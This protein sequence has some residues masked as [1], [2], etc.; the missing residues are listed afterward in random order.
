[1]IIQKNNNNGIGGL[2]D[3]LPASATRPSIPHFPVLPECN[4]IGIGERRRTGIRNS[5]KGCRHASLFAC[6][7]YNARIWGGIALFWGLMIFLVSFRMPLF[8]QE[9]TKPA[10]TIESIDYPNEEIVNAIWLVEGGPK[11]KS[12]SVSCP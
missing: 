5:A 6:L 10:K 9:S 4:S 12:R 7:F 11:Q 3:N 2:Q 8:S 1:M